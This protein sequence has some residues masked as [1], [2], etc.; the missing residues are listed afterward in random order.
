[1]AELLPARAAP[2]G[3]VV[4]LV[5][6]AFAISEARLSAGVAKLRDAGF[7]VRYREDLLSG[8]DYLAGDDARRAAELQE[9]AASPEVHVLLCARGGY[10]CARVAPRLDPALFKRARKPLVGFS[11]ATALLLW[12][13]ARVGLVGFHG[14]MFDG[15][16]EAADDSFDVLAR[17]LRGEALPAMR[18]RGAA[19]GAAEGPLVGGSLT[20]LTASLGTPW[21]VDTRGAILLFEEVGEKPYAIDRALWQLREAGKLQAAAGFGVGQLVGCVDEKRAAPTALQVVQDALGELQKPL[22]LDLPFG[23]C[24]PNFTWPVGVRGRLDAASG[25]LEVLESG[26]TQG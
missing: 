15:D 11:D 17:A 8:E 5:A 1:M 9:W 6:P 22:V 14:P 3:A 21:E 19:S 24:K 18:G 16:V 23:H 20:L 4:A 10:G 26:V 7:Q 12:Q 2:P 25:T 13:R